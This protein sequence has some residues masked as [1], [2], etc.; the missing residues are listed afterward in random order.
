MEKLLGE[1]MIDLKQYIEESLLDDFD[2]LSNNQDYAMEHPF[3]SL[4]KNAKNGN[5]WDNAVNEFENIISSEGEWVRS[6]PRGLAKNE[7]FVAF[8]TED[9]RPDTLR[10][11]VKFN[12]TDFQPFKISQGR[13]G[14]YKE[15]AIT[16][17]EKN[18][19]VNV[20]AAHVDTNVI[21]GGYLLSEK[22]ADDALRML[23]LMSE[24]KWNEKYW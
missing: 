7:V 2:T 6:R 4:Y 19:M 24:Y 3:V 8:Y 23:Q 16:I 12:K 15:P 1:I 9:W 11:Y 13:S 22:H 21:K 20:A 14:V 5:N 17:F 18:G 10:L